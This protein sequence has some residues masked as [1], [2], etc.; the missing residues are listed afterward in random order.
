VAVRGVAD[1]TAPRGHGAR[2]L[3][4]DALGTLVELLPPG[5]ALRRLL[6]E[7]FGVEVSEAQARGAFAAEIGYYRAHMGEGRDEESVRALRA[8]CAEALRAALPRSAPLRAVDGGALTSLLMD[9]LQFR[10]FSDAREALSAARAVGTPVVVASNWDASLPQVLAHTGL[11]EL[12]DGVVCSAVVGAPK[13]SP[14]VFRAALALAGAA[15]REAVHV[16][17]SL[18]ADVAGARAIG[19]RPVLLRR[20]GGPGPAGVTTITSLRALPEICGWSL[21]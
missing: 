10:A 19:I 14:E 20:G 18:D 3:L 1:V 12:L 4:L 2:A 9:A 16:G 21:S 7:R 11:L 8:S 17:D 13:P 15:P 6:A 5:P